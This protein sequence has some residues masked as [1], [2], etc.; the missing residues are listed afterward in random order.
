M[1]AR[2]A[3]DTIPA[4]NPWG[5]KLNTPA[6]LYDRGELHNLLVGRGKLSEEE[7]FKIE[8]HIVQTQIMLSRLPFPK[9]LRGVPEIAG[10]HHEKMDGTGYPRRLFRDD[11]SPLA[12]M[13]AIADMFEAL[14][15]ADR[16][17]K[18]AKTL[19]E[20][21]RI[22]AVA[23]THQHLDPDLFEL[24]LSSSVYRRYAERFM[25]PEQIDD[26]DLGQYMAGGR[27]ESEKRFDD[28]ELARTHAEHR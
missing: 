28:L 27:R 5:F 20:S 25:R 22:M 26:V 14:T 6:H 8:D 13:M 2:T 3:H 1:I 10:N 7:R 23:T 11:M 15:A 17:Y 16:P 12:R 21:V 9:H 18:K 19:S 4:D 24:L